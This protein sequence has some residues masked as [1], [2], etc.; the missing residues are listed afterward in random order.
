MR[1][2]LDTH[3]L[4]WFDIGDARMPARVRRII[5]DNRNQLVLSAVSAYEIAVKFEATNLVLP[6]APRLYLQRCLADLNLD[7]LPINLEHSIA[8]GLLPSHHGDPFDR[9]LVAQSITERMPLVTND[10]NIRK[11]NASLLW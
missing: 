9:M 4:L 5:A 8:A 10:Y 7:V 11:Y 6:E 2:L 1:L 3:A